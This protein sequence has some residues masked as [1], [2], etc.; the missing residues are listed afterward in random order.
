MTENRWLSVDEIAVHLGVGKQSVYRWID[1]KGMPGHR[2]GK[3]WKF[4]MKEVDDWVECGGAGDETRS[5]TSPTKR[6]HM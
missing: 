4:K 3:L 5:G 2:V 1:S 6:G